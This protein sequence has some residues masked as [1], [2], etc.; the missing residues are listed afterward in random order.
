M[1][2]CKWCVVNEGARLKQ[3]SSFRYSSHLSPLCAEC[4]IR[5]VL[6]DLFLCCRRLSPQQL[7]LEKLRGTTGGKT[8]PTPPP[9][10]ANKNIRAGGSFLSGWFV[11][12]RMGECSACFGSRGFLLVVCM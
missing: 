8:Q 2:R 12:W 3:I 1:F 6:L 5:Q 11:R 4:I 9:R 10:A 7:E